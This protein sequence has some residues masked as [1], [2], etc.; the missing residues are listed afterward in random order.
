MNNNAVFTSQDFLGAIQLLLNKKHTNPSRCS[1][2][3]H[4]EVKKG[5]LYLASLTVSQVGLVDIKMNQ[6]KKFLEIW[7]NPH[8][9]F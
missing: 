3:I 2:Y 9:R 8:A 6:A 1:E 7:R 4:D 5:N